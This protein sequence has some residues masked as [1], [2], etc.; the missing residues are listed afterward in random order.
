MQY[1]LS[2]EELLKMKNG[3]QTALGIPFIDAIEDYILEAIWEYAKDIPGIDP[4]YNIRS[5]RLFDVVDET[6]K[7]GWSIKSL[8]WNFKTASTFELVI[9]RADVFKKA[10]NLGFPGLNIESDPN[11]I[12][13]SLIRHW[14]NKILEDAEEQK[15]ID[16]RIFVCLKSLDKTEFIILEEDLSIH[17]ESDLYWKWTDSS[18]SP[19]SVSSWNRTS[20]LKSHKGVKM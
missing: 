9:Q 6:K 10:N 14:N 11:I 2:D 16:K 18:K 5:K 17:G 19:C 1:L 20:A 15:V 13:A 7:I 4:F 12:G 8:Q 3:V